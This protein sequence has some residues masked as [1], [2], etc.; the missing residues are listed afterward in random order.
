MEKLAKLLL[1][2]CGLFM[3]IGI[4]YILFIA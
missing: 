4:I 1:I 3:T 2:L